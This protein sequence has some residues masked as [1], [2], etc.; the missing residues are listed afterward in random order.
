MMKS[1]QKTLMLL[2]VALASVLVSALGY[3]GLFFAIKN[4]T[5]ATTPLLEKIDEL[6][7]REAR[8][9]VST[10][11]LRAQSKNIEKL[12]AYFFK[13]SEVVEF[14]KKVEMLGPESG[15]IVSLESLEG[16][17]TEKTVPYLNFRLTATGEFKSIYRLLLLLESFPGK[18]ELKNVRVFYQ[19]TTPDFVVSGSA[20]QG[21]SASVPVRTP[22]GSW[23]FE[24]TMVAHNFIN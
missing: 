1:K 16:G 4:K 24:S 19:D 5:V 10:N 9:A 23:R 17:V 7:G 8:I 14:T 22:R 6:S 11:V 13:E 15:A 12:S 3:W 20:T 18:I 2:G 21:D